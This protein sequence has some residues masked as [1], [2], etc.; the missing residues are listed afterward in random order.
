MR[1]LD[2]TLLLL[3]SFTSLAFFLL[4]VR[5]DCETAGPFCADHLL[6]VL[7]LALFRQLLLP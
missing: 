7:D 5:F 4:S 2:I 1:H 6:L 3:L